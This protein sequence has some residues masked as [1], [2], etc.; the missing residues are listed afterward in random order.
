[1]SRTRALSAGLALVA[2]AFFVAS[3]AFAAQAPVRPAKALPG[4]EQ[5]MSCAVPTPRTPLGY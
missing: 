1:M 5:Q 4:V 2:T 3:T